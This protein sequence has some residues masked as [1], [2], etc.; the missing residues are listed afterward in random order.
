[1]DGII[2]VD[3]EKNVT[4]RDVVNKYSKILNTKKIGHTGTLDPLATGV[5]VLCVGKGTKL[6]DLI[7][8]YEKEYVAKV[9][10]GLLTDT[11]DITGKVLKEKKSIISEE[12]IEQTLKSF[13]PGYEQ[14]VPI[15][16]AVKINGKKLYEYA[17]NNE[18][19][20]LPK[21]YVKINSINLISNIEYKD[22]KTYFSIITSVSKGTY[23]RSLINDIGKSLNTYGTMMELRRTKQG[24]FKIEQSSN[25]II[26]LEEVLKNYTQVELDEDLYKKISNGVKIKDEYN[27]QFV[28]FTYNKKIIAL[29]KKEEEYLKPYKMF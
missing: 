14:E 18:K 25:N 29:Y 24:Q 19:V 21:R 13:M 6:V 16:S 8:S 20:D 1:M 5:L 12:K 23:I 2:I 17:R 7:T 9:C 3:K 10:L 15:Y 11:Y 26:P 22:N 4:S 27:K 28:A